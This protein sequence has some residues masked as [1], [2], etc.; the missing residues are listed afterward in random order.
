[1]L[2]I[3]RLMTSGIVAFALTNYAHA[4]ADLIATGQLSGTIGDRATQTAAPLENGVAGNLL[5]GIG[6]GV[7]YAGCET[8]LALPDRGPNAVP[9]NAAVDDTVSYINRFQTLRL[10]LRPAATGAALPYSLTPELRATTLLHTDDPLVYG[11]GAA[12]GLPNGVPALNAREHTHYFTGRSDN[13]APAHLSTW[14]LDAR[15]DPESIRVSNDGES[16]Y[17]SDEYGPYIYHFDRRTGRR[18]D[19]VKVP[20]S[21]AVSALSPVGNAEISANTSGRVANKGMEGLAISPDGKTLF[22]AMQ[23]P[24]LQDGGTNGAYTRILRIDLRTGKSQQFAY[25]LS[26][27]GTTAKPKYPTISDVVAVN[28][29]ELLMDER[30]GNGLGDDSTASFKKIFLVD[31]DHAQDVSQ[32]SGEA[33]LAPYAL[34]KTLF[35][36]VVAVLGAHGFATAD[37]PAKLESLAFGEDVIVNGQ[38]RHTLVIANDNDFLGTITDTHHPNGIANPNQFFVFAFS[39]ADLPGFTPQN[40]RTQ[41]DDD[42]DDPRHHDHD[43]GQGRG[44]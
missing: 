3:H 40:L 14:P 44:H 5:G 7:A 22:G 18:I 33:G 43:D 29:H 6:S 35:L 1:M 25:P 9:F 23:S 11:S 38:R 28:D 20:D 8:F 42:R 2:Q 26:N 10:R 4:A 24:L 12:Q 34:S 21:F 31:L 39:S 17:I 32:T 41:C 37:I 27:I 16:V 15:L 30:D 13:F 19:V 36:D